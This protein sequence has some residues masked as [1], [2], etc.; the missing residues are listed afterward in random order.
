MQPLKLT[1]AHGWPARMPREGTLEVDFRTSQIVADKRIP[2]APSQFEHVFVSNL[3]PE[4]EVSDAH[5]T[6]FCQARLLCCV[7][8]LGCAIER[9]AVSVSSEVCV[10]VARVYRACFRAFGGMSPGCICECGCTRTNCCMCVI[11]LMKECRSR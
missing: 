1:E 6:N 7:L 11:T 4:A 10:H 2:L 8:A 9:L 5:R 3:A